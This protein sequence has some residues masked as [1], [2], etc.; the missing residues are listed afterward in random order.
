MRF[1]PQLGVTELVDDGNGRRLHGRLAQELLACDLG[2][3]IDLSATGMR[4]LARRLPS[5]EFEAEIYGA[6]S[7]RVRVRCKVRWS[8]QTGRKQ[9]EVG[10]EFI[11]PAPDLLQNLTKIAMA[12]RRR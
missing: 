7:D 2:E 4:V 8:R 11:D 1:D 5:R 6:S 10:L 3:V 9:F 12:H